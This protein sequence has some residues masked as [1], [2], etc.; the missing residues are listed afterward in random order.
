[1]LHEKGRRIDILMLYMLVSYFYLSGGFGFSKFANV[2]KFPSLWYTRLT[3][4][5]VLGGEN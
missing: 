5:N 4:G 3:P 1:M 2:T